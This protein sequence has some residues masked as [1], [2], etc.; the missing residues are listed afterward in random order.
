MFRAFHIILQQFAGPWKL[1]LRCQSWGMYIMITVCLLRSV[2][3]Q[4]LSSLPTSTPVTVYGTL[5]LNGQHYHSTAGNAT[6]RPDMTGYLNFSPTVTLY[7]VQFPF[8]FHFTTSESSFRQPFNEFGVS[9]RYKWITG[10][11]GYRS[12]T[13]SPFT[14]AYQR[15]LGAGLDLRLSDFRISMMY[16]RFQKATEEDTTARITAMY[17]RMGYAVKAGFGSEQNTVDVTYFR[18]WDDSASVSHVHSGL[19][20]KPAENAVLSIGTRL[21][22]LDSR[23][24]FEA[25]AAGS[26]YT[27]DMAAPGI[28]SGE[29][30]NLFKL[31]LTPRTSTQAMWALRSS[32]GYSDKNVRLAL[33]YER[34][35]PDFQ[36]MGVGYITGDREDIT[37]APSLLLFRILRIN[38][39]V[40]IR[41]NNLWNDKLT[42]SR[43]LIV[44]GG[45]SLQASKDLGLDL[46]YS[47]YASHTTDGRISVNDT[48]RLESVAQSFSLG[49]RY[50]IGDADARH[51]FSLMLMY[52]GY[53]D[54]NLLSNALNNT[55][56]R[57]ATLGYTIA[58][59]T[60]SLNCSATQAVAESFTYTNTSTS[61]Q[62]NASR[63]FFDR[64]LS[65]ALQAS[66]SFV[67]TPATR[68]SRILPGMN[69]SYR[70]SDHDALTMR[71]QLSHNTRSNNPST[72]ILTAVGFSKTF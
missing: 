17:T 62:M 44:S 54:R 28:E 11:F 9:P 27:R 29:L 66:Y 71:T 63:T 10:H 41:R 15:W 48:T 31:F 49:S 61:V 34:V 2:S 72:E 35:E 24:R 42:T 50:S 18:G 52:S 30:I 58:R 45:V 60:Y 38:G 51:T 69:L 6:G 39:S 16:G 56:T 5:S 36:S 14:L 8:Q 59:N 43:R 25:E 46:R 23:I 70:L 20:P 68:D 33:K 65:V 12:V 4:D 22:L 40:G 13:Y 7:G 32:V 64:S 57:T 3:G 19:S 21:S 37:L 53:V 1:E 55:R 26:A 47:N 67:R